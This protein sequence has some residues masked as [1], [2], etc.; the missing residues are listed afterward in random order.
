MHCINYARIRVFICRILPHKDRIYD[1]VSLYRR[2][3]FVKVVFSHILYSDFF[4]TF[5]NVIENIIQKCNRLYASRH[6]NALPCSIIVLTQIQSVIYRISLETIP[7]LT[8]WFN[9]RFSHEPEV[10]CTP[11]TSFEKQETQ[12]RKDKYAIQNHVQIKSYASF[13]SFTE[14]SSLT[15]IKICANF[16]WK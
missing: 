16:L 14:K 15:T 9:S 13:C 6:K 7:Y 2:I 4:I 11:A 5:T 1:C 8:I 3:W 12:M 10:R